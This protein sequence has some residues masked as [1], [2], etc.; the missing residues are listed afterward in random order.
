[1]LRHKLKWL[2]Q[3]DAAGDKAGAQRVFE[4]LPET[5]RAVLS[6]LLY[7]GRFAGFRTRWTKKRLASLTPKEAVH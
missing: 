4:S 1:M 2:Y 3:L 5:A 6:L 7:V